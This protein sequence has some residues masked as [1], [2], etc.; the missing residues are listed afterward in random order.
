MSAA[1]TAV[2]YGSQAASVLYYKAQVLP[3]PE[4]VLREERVLLH[5]LLHLPDKVFKGFPFQAIQE[6]CG[7]RFVSLSGVGVASKLR[8][9]MLLMALVVLLHPRSG[10]LR[11]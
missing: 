8:W 3:L 7:V 1:A 5:K 9:K 2:I 10:I 11:P 6:F 4:S